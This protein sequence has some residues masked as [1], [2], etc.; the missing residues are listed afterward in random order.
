NLS[1][2]AHA[3]AKGIMEL[4][5]Q[6]SPR[7]VVLV[8]GEKSRMSYLKSKIMGEFGCPCYDP[9]NGELLEIETGQDVRALM[10]DQLF[11]AAWAKEQERRQKSAVPSEDSVVPAATPITQLPVRGVLLLGDGKRPARLLDPSEFDLDDIPVVSA[12]GI[13]ADDRSDS[14]VAA[15]TEELTPSASDQVVFS[16]RRI[17]DGAELAERMGLSSSVDVAAAALLAIRELL[18]IDPATQP[19]DV[20]EISDKRASVVRVGRSI[21]LSVPAKTAECEL[22]SLYVSWAWEE[23]ELATQVLVVINRVLG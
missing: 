8:H 2:S 12:S 15:D 14:I 3:D 21:E 9:A 20:D 10:S 6:A 23:E 13:E 11:Q 4:I 1:F 7:N 18:L 17:F 16:T 22:P 19:K 5:R